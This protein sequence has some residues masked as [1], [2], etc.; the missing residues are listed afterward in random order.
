MGT[1]KF[2][3]IKRRTRVNKKRSLRKKI[4]GGSFTQSLGF[5]GLPFF[6]KTN[7]GG[8][9]NSETNELEKC[10]V[11]GPFKWCKNPR[12]NENNQPQL[13]DKLESEPQPTA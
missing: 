6:S 1:K 7:K 4:K 11:L 2:K 3:H 5:W 10:Y 8:V 13:E 12:K 9:Y